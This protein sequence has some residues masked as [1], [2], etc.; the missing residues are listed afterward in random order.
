MQILGRWDLFIQ[1][2]KKSYVAMDSIQRWVVMTTG[3]H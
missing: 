2:D 1:T 3:V